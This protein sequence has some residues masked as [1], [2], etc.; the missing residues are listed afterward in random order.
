MDSFAEMNETISNI[1]LISPSSDNHA[2][3]MLKH[4]CWIY[5]G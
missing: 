5:H 1:Q 2:S 3:S 4:Y